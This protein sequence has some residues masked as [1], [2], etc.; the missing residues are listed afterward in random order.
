MQKVETSI[1]D[2]DIII[3]KELNQSQS[4]GKDAERRTSKRE[5]KEPIHT[6]IKV[7]PRFVHIIVNVL[8]KSIRQG[9][10][11]SL[12]DV[13]QHHEL[14]QIIVKEKKLKIRVN[15]GVYLKININRDFRLLIWLFVGVGCCLLANVHGHSIAGQLFQR[16]ILISSIVRLREFFRSRSPCLSRFVLLI[17]LFSLGIGQNRTLWLRSLALF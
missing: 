15:I 2:S 14:K 4:T 5:N 16:F 17:S 7:V 8:Q 10:E 9:L 3:I 13:D 1:K 11:D 12:N 6:V